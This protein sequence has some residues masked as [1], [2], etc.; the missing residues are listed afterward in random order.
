MARKNGPIST[1]DSYLYKRARATSPTCMQCLGHEDTVEHT[2][3][4]FEQWEPFREELSFRLGHRPTA[5]DIQELICGPAF[6]V[7][8]A[9]P[10]DKHTALSEAE[11]RFRLF[12]RM[13]ERIM[14]V[15]EDQE[16]ARQAE[17]ARAAE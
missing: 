7:L 6:G 12:Y 1:S 3:F 4:E 15:K 14:K 11:K 2:L 17:E 5:L 8:P 16:R 13:V 10:A 9:D